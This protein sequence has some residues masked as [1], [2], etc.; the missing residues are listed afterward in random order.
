[1][2]VH[3]LRNALVPVVTLATLEGPMALGGAFVV[4][5]VLSLR[6]VGELTILAVQQR[7]IAWL[8]AISLSAALI[9]AVFVVAADLAQAIVDPRIAGA[10][11]GRKGRP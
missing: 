6:G 4:E 11:L 7:D 10:V 2:V 1:V 5:R 9:A 3:A 8:M